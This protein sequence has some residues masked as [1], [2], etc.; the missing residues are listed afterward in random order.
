M[1]YINHLRGVPKGEAYKLYFAAINYS[2]DNRRTLTSLANVG[3][4]VISKDGGSFVSATNALGDDDPG[5]GLF[6]LQLTADEMD[7]DK[8]VGRVQCRIGS[9]DPSNDHVFIFV[10]DTTTSSGGS[11]NSSTQGMSIAA[12]STMV[13][14][15]SVGYTLTE[16]ALAESNYN[17]YGLVKN[18]KIWIVI[19]DKVDLTETDYYQA[20]KSRQTFGLGWANRATLSYK[21]SVVLK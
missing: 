21:E 2:G 17:Y 16:Y 1:E 8:I 20:P 15:S 13:K 3:G 4:A 7:A 14:A 9:D 11:G 6:S 5:T 12:L 18:G 10:I 19:R